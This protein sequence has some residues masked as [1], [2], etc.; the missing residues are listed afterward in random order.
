VEPDRQPEPEPN[1]VAESAS[2]RPVAATPPWARFA[3]FLGRPPG[4]LTDRQWRVLGL[5]SLVS[6]FEQYDLYLFALNLKHIQADLGLAE[7]DLGWLGS[8]VR[9]GALPA[10][11]VTLA[12]D[13]VGRRRV[14][15]FTVIAYTLLTGATALAPNAETFVVLQFLA[16]TFAIAETLVAI[17]VIAEEFSPENRGWGIGAL[18]AIQACGAGMAALLFGLVEYLPFGWRALY[19]VGLVPLLLVAWW[20]RTLPETERFESL[21]A[22]RRE[23]FRATPAFAP[24]LQLVRDYPGRF[25]AV[26][27][28]F[29]AFAIAGNPAGF[30]APKYLQDAHAW[31]PGGVAM[32]NL[33]G[34]GLAILANPLAGRLGDRY[35]RRPVAIAF[36]LGWIAAALAF[37]NAPGAVVGALWVA[38]IF[39]VF[40]AETTL[41]AYSVEI[42]P[43][44]QR[45]TASGARTLVGTVGAVLGLGAVSMLYGTFGSNW[46]AIS[47]LMLAALVIPPVILAAFPETAR[48]KLEEVAPE[49]R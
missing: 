39:G 1:P 48:R 36:F 28:A 23:S 14:L 41:A 30:F 49:L 5:V 34:G 42:F 26:A 13:R 44:S 20:R 46:T 25:A 29:F 24:M 4:G 6:L 47:V 16:R 15:L 40:G 31:T 7:S 37:Y 3:W 8:V 11:L 9:A 18:G 2:S 10:V 43:T 45:A 35:G 22:E 38:M 27:A 33:F 17:V 21:A 32:L 19:L 12:A